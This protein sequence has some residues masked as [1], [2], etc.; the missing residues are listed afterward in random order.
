MYSLYTTHIDSKL[1][2]ST[3]KLTIVIDSATQLSVGLLLPFQIS[4]HTFNCAYNKL[5]VF[6]T[7][8]FHLPAVV[9]VGVGVGPAVRLWA[10]SGHQGARYS[11]LY[12]PWRVERADTARVLKDKRIQVS[13]YEYI[14]IKRF[15][16][17]CLEQISSL[18]GHNLRAF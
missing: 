7:I 11:A 2:I 12:R 17:F 4:G 3:R 8:E 5:Y 6:F 9:G 15:S 16:T 10:W 1:Q 13:I 14:V 18:N